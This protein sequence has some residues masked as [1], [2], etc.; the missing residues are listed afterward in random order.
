M[1]AKFWKWLGLTLACLLLMLGVKTAWAVDAVQPSG[2]PGTASPGTVSPGTVEDLQNQQRQ[3]EA[4]RLQIDQQQQ[5]LQQQEKA[6]HQTLKNSQQQIKSTSVEIEQNQQRLQQK[7]QQLKLLVQALTKAEQDYNLQQT[8]TV[9]RLRFLQRQGS[10]YGWAVLLQSKD[11]NEFL[12][13][14]QQLRRLYLADQQI[15][16]QLKTEADSIA[17]QRRT[18]ETQKNEIALLTQELLAQKLDSQESAKQQQ[19]LIS[20]LRLDKGALE[21]AETQLAKDSDNMT[22]LIQRRK[23]IFNPSVIL[24]PGKGIF[25]QPC[26]GEITSGFGYRIH[27][28]LGY[29][30]FHSGLDFGADYG[31]PIR[32]PAPGKVLF[33]GWYGGYGQAVILDHG[34]NVTT[35]YAHAS[36]IYISEGQVVQRG[37]P[38]AAVGSTGLSTGPHLHFEVRVSGTPVDPQKYL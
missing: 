37:T 11:L 33:A 3:I 9:A 24:K 7:S 25:S 26:A 18:V 6:A 29:S 16:A 30:R 32:A 5:R 14:R 36:E 8:A 28:I 15:L 31:T 13:R 21:A 12:D 27:P 1:L 23:G 34:N 22:I 4:D 35:L 38:I 17:Q 20:R 2:S 10:S 19:D